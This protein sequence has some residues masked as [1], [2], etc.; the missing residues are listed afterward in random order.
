M[1]DAE[2]RALM[3]DLLPAARAKAIVPI[4]GFAVGAVARGRSGALHLGSNLEFP[5]HPL[6]A[7]VH[8]EQAA[9]VSAWMRGEHGI[10]V[11]A[12]TET[13]CGHCRQ[14]LNE[15]ASAEDL[16][17]LVHGKAA[18]R[19]SD[20]LPAAFGPSDLGISAALMR[21]DPQPLQLASPDSHNGDEAGAALVAE[22]L[23]AAQRS[24][25]PYSKTYSGVALGL[26][27]GSVRTGRYAESAAFNPSLSPLQI[28]LSGLALDGIPF[29]AIRAAALVE[30]AGPASQEQATEA[31]LATV[32]PGIVLT[33]ARAVST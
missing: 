24:Y 21:S 20:L 15:L 33:Y 16:T 2:N 32:A 8:A 18:V 22:A 28:A 27:D 17:V 31:L 12:T 7:S 25:A 29:A 11:L 26:A 19:L 4:S 9:V 23:E 1:S 5:G 10:D 3:D 14:F 6:N 30:T 13:P